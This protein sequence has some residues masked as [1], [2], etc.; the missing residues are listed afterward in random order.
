MFGTLEKGRRELPKPSISGKWDEGLWAEMEDGSRVELW[1]PAPPPPDPTRSA[2]LDFENGHGRLGLS[3]SFMLLRGDGAALG[4]TNV[5][6]SSSVRMLV[7]VDVGV[8]CSPL[9]SR[10][11]SNG[12]VPQPLTAAQFCFA[13]TNSHG[14]RY[15]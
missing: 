3:L 8:A 15:S 2:V 10:G 14:G 11:A 9:L 5:H 1:R 12:G 6:G 4:D 13:G 7:H